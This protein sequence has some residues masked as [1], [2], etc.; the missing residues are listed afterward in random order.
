MKRQ[1]NATSSPKTPRL[2]W[3]YP[4]KPIAD[5]RGSLPQTADDLGD[6]FT[7]DG[8]EVTPTPE[9]VAAH[10]LRAFFECVE[11]SSLRPTPNGYGTPPYPVTTGYGIDNRTGRAVCYRCCGARDRATMKS[12]GRATLYLCRKPDAPT[13]LAR[14]ETKVSPIPGVAHWRLQPLP[15]D[16]KVTNWPSSLELP[17]WRIRRSRHNWGRERF[18]VWFI[19]EGY[20][21]HGVNAGDSQ[22]LHARRT[23]TVW[24]GFGPVTA[25]KS[26]A[27]SAKVLA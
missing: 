6:P 22:L 21:W 13:A 18:D 23:R 12:N 15:Q 3:R 25:S 20:V 8:A 4:A 27:K 1:R 24:S 19:F 14:G 11:C 26:R 2:F 16:W 10:G 17:V 9:E 7:R 5:Y